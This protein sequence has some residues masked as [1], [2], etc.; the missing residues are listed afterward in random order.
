MR[1][2]LPTVI[3]SHEVWGDLDAGRIERDELAARAAAAAG[4]DVADVEA[5]L[6]GDLA[7]PR[8]A[9]RQPGT[10]WPGYATPATGSSSCPTCRTC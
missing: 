10:W 7:P 8:R 1:T 2:A 6:D 5:L 9:A 4:V 3:F